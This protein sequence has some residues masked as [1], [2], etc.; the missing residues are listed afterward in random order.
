MPV[1]E[2]DS[3]L[4]DSSLSGHGEMHGFLRRRTH[5]TILPTPLPDDQSS[6]LNDYYFTDS[7]TQDSMSV[8]DACLHN[9]H[10]VPRAKEVF[11]RLRESKQGDPVLEA[12]VYNLFLDAYLEMATSKDVGNRTM[13][14]EELWSLY[15]VMETGRE[16]VYPTANTF[17][18]MLQAWMRFN[19]DSKEPVMIS[20]AKV[21]DPISLLRSIIDCQISVS[22]VISDRAFTSNEEATEAIKHLSKAAVAM[23]LAN[24]VNELGLADS[25]GREVEDPLENVPEAIP[26]LRLKKKQQEIH[27]TRSEDGTRVSQITVDEVPDEPEF[28]VPFNLESLRR[29]LSHVVLA[30]RVLPEDVASRQKLLEHSVY[31]VAVERLKHQ[32]DLFDELGLTPKGLK[33]ADLQSWMWDWH[34]KLQ[35]RLKAEIERVNTEESMLLKKG[36]MGL[37]PFLSLLK[38][39]KLSLITILEL[40]HLQGSGGVTD[41]MKTARA[42][43]AVGKAVELEYKAEMCKKNNIPIPTSNP[44]RPGDNNVFTNIGYKDLYVR[45]VAAQKFMEDSEEWTSDWSQLVRVKMGSFL[46]DCLMDVATVMRTAVDKRTGKTLRRSSLRS[47]IRMNIY[48]DASLEGYLFNRTW[49]MRFKDSQE[50]QSYL[51]HAAAQGNLELVFA[52]LDV[53]GST[54]WKINR[55]IFDVV[56]Q[57]QKAWMQGKANNHSDRCNI[58]YKVEIARAFLGDTIYMPHNVDF[59]GR[60]YPIPPHLNHI[61]DDLSRGLLMFDESKPLGE[62]GL[63]WLK[64]HLANLFGYDKA[65]FDER[66][67]FVHDHLEDIYDS[68]EHPLD[69]KGWW[70]KADDP[71]QCLATCKELTKALESPDPLAYECALPVHQDGTCNG[72]QHYAALGGDAVGAAQVNL[73]ATERP[74]DVYT[75]VAQ[76]V[77]AQL[78]QD[79]AK[80]HK[81]AKMLSGK[82]SR[83]VVKQTVMTTV[84]GVTFIGAREQIEKQLKARDDIPTEE[85]WLAAAYLAKKVLACI[86]D[87]FK[88]AK[89]IQTWLNLCA[90][91]IS[92]SIPE[93][94]LE[95][96]LAPLQR[97]KKGPAPK[98][99][100]QSRLKKEQMTS[101]VW[102]TPLGL[103]I[104]QPYRATK[105]K[106]IMTALQTVF[107]SDPNVPSAVNATKQASAFPPNFIHSLDATHMMLTALECRAQGLTFASVHDSYWTH[108]GSIDQMSAIIRDTFIA[109][110]SSNVLEKLDEEFRE[111]YKGYR[112]SIN[113]LRSITLLR[114]LGVDESILEGAVDD[115]LPESI[116]EEE[117]EEFAAFGEIDDHEQPH[118]EEKPQAVAKK[119]RKKRR[120]INP[121]ADD[122][123]AGRF[124]ALTDLIPPL[125]KKGEFDV[126]TIKK[127][128]Y[129]F[130]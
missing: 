16:K 75:Y 7:P 51:R 63:R 56:L 121:T 22:L 115:T 14:L 25:L 31:D 125:P 64:I 53:L 101:V 45:R 57:R 113:H 55:D 11:E 79:V 103:P 92:K 24:V 62:R 90:R 126:T 119:S 54:P 9:W 105:R 37:S 118:E 114:R 77:E 129:F 73:A 107:I 81:F 96:A 48:E 117:D 99:S 38:I 67:Q 1:P 66:V 35:V 122:P 21:H 104:V 10:D 49:A 89:D 94:R 27:V 39:E 88:G 15:D 26:V 86:G 61:G 71:W 128:L 58:N 13:W 109:L 5:Y 50:Q 70:K 28:E 8:M 52:G 127:S 78:Q 120:V 60:A 111:R 12:R 82:I 17:A 34:Q 32:S 110:H 19:P 33:N 116:K 112:V 85:C 44:A 123:Y 2:S 30:R 36:D 87:L 130:S 102:T 41:G 65:S 46:V 124:V 74:S 98:A 108:A 91:L 42:L 4:S 100:P 47:S 69:G 68:A 76:M 83:K 20:G 95:A 40:M 43:L 97:S 93:D 59:R 72:L 29:H 3:M 23:D 80:D 6:A 18:I 106:Q 84:Y